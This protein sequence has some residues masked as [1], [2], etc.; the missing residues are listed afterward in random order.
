MP[1]R[2]LYAQAVLQGEPADLVRRFHDAAAILRN[3]IAADVNAED[4]FVIG[5]EVDLPD[6]REIVS[7]RVRTGAVERAGRGWWMPLGWAPCS[8]NRPFPVFEGGIELERTAGTAAAVSVSGQYRIPRGALHAAALLVAGEA[9][10]RRILNELASGLDGTDVWQDQSVLNR[11][12]RLTVRSVMSKAPLLFTE[13]MTV[14]TAARLLHEHGFGGAPVV[15]ADRKPLGVLSDADLLAR[16]ASPRNHRGLLQREQVRR[17]LATT[18]GE[19][20]SRPAITVRAATPLRE[21]ARELL[22]RDIA[23]LVVVDDDGRVEGI[24]TRKDILPVIARTNA[25]LQRLIGRELALLG[26]AGVTAQV[27]GAGHATLAG[28]VP[29]EPTA[30]RAVQAAASIDGVTTVRDGR[31]HVDERAGA[32]RSS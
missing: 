10:A 22:D 20:C 5:A 23:R 17:R 27:S 28:A 24:I 7:T 2:W 29:D 3:R 25:G 6:A 9:V 11:P 14:A 30:R 26:I 18:V 15:D 8:P 31:P 19:A 21:A 13:D 1:T 4:G 32:G 16:E 12:A